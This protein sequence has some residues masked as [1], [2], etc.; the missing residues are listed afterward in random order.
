MEKKQRKN[1]D[2]IHNKVEK[3]QNKFVIPFLGGEKWGGGEGKSWNPWG[4]L[5]PSGTKLLRK[6]PRSKQ[7][8]SVILRT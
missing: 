3:D 7:R 1:K 6:R 5:I 8:A 2:K 4:G